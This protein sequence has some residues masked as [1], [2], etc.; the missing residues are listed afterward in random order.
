MEEI[1]IKSLL[2]QNYV[3]VCDTNVYLNVYRYSPEFTEFSMKCLNEIKGKIVIPA[4]VDIEYRKHCKSEYFAMKNRV[5][6]AT[7]NILSQIDSSKKKIS[8]TCD[9]LKSLQYP[10][11]DAMPFR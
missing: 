1:D 9:L 3:I 5:K 6:K 10:D 8:N 11:I 2:E 4:T 7:S